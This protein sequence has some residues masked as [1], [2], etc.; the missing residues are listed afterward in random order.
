MLFLELE[1]KRYINGKKYL[2]LD[3]KKYYN[4]YDLF[5]FEFKG[6][7][8]VIEKIYDKDLLKQRISKLKGV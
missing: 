5:R 1:D 8:K 2:N 3:N 6:L 7:P 4:H